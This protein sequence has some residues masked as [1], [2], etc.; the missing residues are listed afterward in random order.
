M[1]GVLNFLLKSKDARAYF[2]RKYF[3]FY[4]IPMLN[5]DGVFNGHYRMDLFN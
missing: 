5:P 3:L 2:L 4:I 1:N